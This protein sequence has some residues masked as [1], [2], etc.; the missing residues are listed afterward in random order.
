MKDFIELEQNNVIPV[1]V[2]V[3]TSID[4]SI[5]V[6]FKYA[7]YDTQ[8]P[9]PVV[10][11]MRNV[12]C[13]YKTNKKTGRVAG[14]NSYISIP[15]THLAES[16]LVENAANLAPYVAV[17]LASVED[18][19]IK[20]A[21]T[22]GTIGFNS[23]WLGLDKIL[24]YLDTEGSGNRLNKEV[25]G[26]WFDSHILE[27]LSQGVATKMG[28]ESLEA[29]SDSELERVVAMCEAYKIKFQGLASGRTVYVIGEIE[30]LQKCLMIATGA[31]TVDEMHKMHE[32]SAV[33]E[34]GAKFW[35]R[36]ENMRDAG[37]NAGLMEL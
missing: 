27:P 9:L 23:S 3:A 11:G 31:A 22:A 16:V 1:A 4:T 35:V 20:A 25:I 17:Y 34:M 12:K 13:L 7:P 15:D 28:L 8:L 36:L 6:A 5:A 29:A 14:E 37:N 24:G 19:I 2:D 10:A 33:N 21:H 18:K 30:Q 26:E 32:M